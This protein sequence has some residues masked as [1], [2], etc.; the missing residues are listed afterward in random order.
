MTLIDTIAALKKPTA[1]TFNPAIPIVA[2][3]RTIRILLPMVDPAERASKNTK[4]N[5][6]CRFTWRSIAVRFTG[7]S[8]SRKE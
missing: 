2:N 7:G 4:R 6:I 8:L 3:R 5:M 1:T